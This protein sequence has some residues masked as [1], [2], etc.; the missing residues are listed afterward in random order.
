MP[1]DPAKARAY[2]LMRTYGI[3]PEQYDALLQFQGGTCFI[4]DKPPKPGKNLQVDHDHVTGLI[5]GLL[6]WSCNHRFIGRE[7]DPGRFYMGWC[8]LAD[9][10]ARHIIGE[11]IVP[12]KPKKKRKKRS[13]K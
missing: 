3:T 7:R 8:Y 5:R 13:S 9:P 4:C 10:P 6:C 11:H 12:P 2:R 1:T